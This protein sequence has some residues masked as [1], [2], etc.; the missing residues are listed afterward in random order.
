MKKEEN[1]FA[2]TCIENVQLRYR[3][4]IL[5][6]AVI[7]L[8]SCAYIGSGL[9]EDITDLDEFLYRIEQMIFNN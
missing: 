9:D 7:D 2:Q 4:K 1:V 6:E 8:F 5:E 3:N